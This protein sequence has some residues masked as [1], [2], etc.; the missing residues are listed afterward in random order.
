VDKVPYDRNGRTRKTLARGCIAAAGLLSWQECLHI[1]FSHLDGPSRLVC[2]QHW[3]LFE[4]RSTRHGHGSP[5]AV[6]SSHLDQVRN[7]KQGRTIA[8][9][10]VSGTSF[11]GMQWRP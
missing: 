7:L 6:R 10:S 4:Q 11:L 5:S 9:I 1:V 3:D 2:T 8:R